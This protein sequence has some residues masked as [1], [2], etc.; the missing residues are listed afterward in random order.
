MPDGYNQACINRAC[1]GGNGGGGNWFQDAI[2]VDSGTL[3]DPDD[4]DGTMGAPYSSIQTAIVRAEELMNELPPMTDP[5]VPI[6]TRNR[7]R[8]VI[9]VAGGIYPEDL[10]TTR[11]NMFLVLLALGPVTLGDAAVGT[12]IAGLFEST[13]PYSVT[14][15]NSQAVEEAD[16]PGA[17]TS[18]D[19]RRP[20]FIMGV[21]PDVGPMTSTQTAIASGWVISG[22]MIFTSADVTTTEVHLQNVK[23]VGTVDGTTDSGISNCYI[24]NCKFEAIDWDNAN[25]QVVNVTEFD[26]PTVLATYGRLTQCEI[27]GGFTISGVSTA[28]PPSGMFQCDISGTFTGPAS[29]CRLDGTSNYFFKTNGATLAGGAT[30]VILDDLAA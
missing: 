7:Q 11:G 24:D 30:K 3:V 16:S 19:D 10:S 12:P 28:L 9:I 6:G 25:F 18:E 4:Q 22:D 5:D 13:V 21:F 8:Q 1:D 29:S 2:W 27:D 26:G 20:Q 14:V 15:F 23:V 17:I